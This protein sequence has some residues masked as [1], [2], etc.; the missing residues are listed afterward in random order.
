MTTEA[1]IVNS[2]DIKIITKAIESA[3]KPTNDSVKKLEKQ[4]SNLPCGEHSL[5]I[6]TLE[7][8]RDEAEKQEVKTGKSRDWML[9]IAVAVMGILAF[10]DKLGV[11]KAFAK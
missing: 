10:L 8:Q 6:N 7:T 11:F 5:S 4:M 2:E 1:L 9:R 3:I